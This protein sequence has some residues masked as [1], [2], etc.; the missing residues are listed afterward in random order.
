MK[1]KSLFLLLSL[2]VFVAG[3]NAQKVVFEDFE[4]SES[5]FY[6][7]AG[8]MGEVSQEYTA[9]PSKTG[10]NTSEGVLAFT[11]TQ[12]LTIGYA[13]YWF[14]L[15]AEKAALVKPQDTRYMHVKYYRTS[16]G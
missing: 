11:V 16:E 1:K 14:G 5:K 13:G 7:N 8:V 3:L 12:P 4:N 15:S 6:Q 10:I 9:N 2:C